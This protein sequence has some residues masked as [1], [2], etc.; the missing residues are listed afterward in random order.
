MNVSPAAE[1]GM[2]RA[3]EI[4]RE[5]GLPDNLTP[6]V[7]VQ[8]SVDMYGDPAF[9]ENVFPMLCR[10]ILQ[11]QELARAAK[12]VALVHDG[13]PQLAMQRPEMNRRG[14]RCERRVAQ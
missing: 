14:R 4:M 13:P 1:A 6:A 3:N 12:D 10:A 5:L 8:K 11:Q 2:R 7:A 9:V